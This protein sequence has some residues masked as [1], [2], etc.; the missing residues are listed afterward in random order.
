M[1]YVCDHCESLFE[2]EDPKK[3]RC[4]TCLRAHGVRPKEWGSRSSRRRLHWLVVGVVALLVCGVGS[5]VVYRLVSA[6]M[7]APDPVERARDRGQA[8][9]LAAEARELLD[10]GDRKA[11]YKR[12]EAAV[13]ADSRLAAA[14]EVLGDV[15]LASHAGREA[16]AEYEAALALEERGEL[17][18]KA[19]NLYLVAGATGAAVRHLGRALELDPDAEW[20]ERVRTALGALVEGPLPGESAAATVAADGGRGPVDGGASGAPPPTAPPPGPAGPVE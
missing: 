17:H 3:P 9:R 16:L 20:A 6:R 13:R 10:A 19:G 15:L 5:G 11:A 7:A 2:P 18:V 12:A 14:R 4:P 1:W 8:A